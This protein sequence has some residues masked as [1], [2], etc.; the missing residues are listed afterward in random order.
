MKAVVSCLLR[1]TYVRIGGK[2]YSQTLGVGMGQ[3][4]AP[5]MAQLY[6][7]IKERKWIDKKLR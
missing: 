2:I 3:E 6:M 7:H 4:S 1:E 5:P